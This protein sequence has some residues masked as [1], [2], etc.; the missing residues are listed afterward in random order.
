MSVSDIPFVSHGPCRVVLIA[1]KG[2]YPKRVCH[3]T[4]TSGQENSWAIRDYLTEQIVRSGDSTM[5]A[6]Q[7]EALIDY[8]EKPA[9]RSVNLIPLWRADCQG[10]SERHFGAVHVDPT[11]P[12]PATLGRWRHMTSTRGL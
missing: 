11:T 8:A 6:S 5:T 3:Y 4:K 1:L 2:D 9:F 7:I 12:N 10:A